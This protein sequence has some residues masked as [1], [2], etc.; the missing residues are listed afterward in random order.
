MRPRA[1]LAQIAGQGAR[2]IVVFAILFLALSAAVPFAIYHELGGQ[3]PALD[4]RLFSPLAIAACLALLVVYF[5]ADGLRLYYAVR[6]LGY[7]VPAAHMARL[8]FINFLISNITPMATGGG[9]AQIGYLR[10]QGVHLGAATAATT[11]RTLL[12]SLLIFIPTP[13]LM[14]FMSPLQDSAVASRWGFY[15]GLLAALYVGFFALAL[16]RPRWMMASGVGLL[17]FLN[18]A[19]VIGE[20]RL[21][22]WRFGLRREM[23]RFGAALRAYLKGPRRYVML[24][25]LFTVLFLL[26]L[27][28]FPAVLLWALGY[29]IDYLAVIGLMVVTTFVMYFAPTPGAA[30]IAEGV[31]AMFFAGLVQADHLL[32]MVVAWRALTI[33]LGMLIGVPIT[34]HALAGG[35]RG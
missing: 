1:V 5:V 34:L 28:S 14:W 10:G 24:S 27:F 21:R 16:T 31:F 2:R 4:G 13:F 23:V 17:K 29:H 9:F 19:G 15:L 35:A 25:V 30:G 7:H 3:W 33:Y 26:T 11:L 6:A 20:R 12:A 32:L 8:V 22:R 18:R